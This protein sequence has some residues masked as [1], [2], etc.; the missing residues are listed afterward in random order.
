MYFKSDFTDILT[1]SLH[2]TL[3]LINPCLSTSM[4]IDKDDTLFTSIMY[5][6]NQ[7]PLVVTWD[8]TIVTVLPT[9]GVCG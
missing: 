8:D 1:E 4:E 9:P 2:F 3:N 5:T 7:G 6:L